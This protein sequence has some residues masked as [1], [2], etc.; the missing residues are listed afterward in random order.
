MTAESLAT[1]EGARKG[2]RST[3]TLHARPAAEL[4]QLLLAVSRGDQVALGNLYDLT[5]AK[6]YGLARTMLRNAADAE[7]VVCDTYVQAW[8]SAARFDP[9][10]G[11]VLAWLLVI[12]RSR[13]LDLL[14]QRRSRVAAESALSGFVEE[15]TEPAPEDLLRH[16]QAGTAIRHALGAL[17]PLRQ[18]LVALAFFRGMS[19]QE[20]AQ[21]VQLPV[22]TVKSHLRRS[23]QGMR[24]VLDVDV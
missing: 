7:E 22:G 2:P 23:L 14:R 9:E 17:T 6:L 15:S 20:I 4:A 24:A 1:R 5:A 21:A 11:S 8:Q 16:V 10:R 12:C 3:S 13:A 19:H 18:Q